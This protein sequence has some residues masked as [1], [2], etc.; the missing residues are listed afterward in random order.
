MM[1][2]G[3]NKL[4]DSIR[5][6]TSECRRMPDAKGAVYLLGLIVLGVLGNHLNIELFFGVNFLF[7][8][9]ATMIAVRASGTLWGTVVGIAIGAYTYFLWGHPYAI[10][11]FGLEAF[12]VGFVVCALKKDNMVLADVGFWLVIGMPLV[13]VLYT[14]QL[15]LP[16][17]PV[18]LIALKQTINGI[19]NTFVATLFLQ[20]APQ[21]L[22]G[23]GVRK[24][25]AK[26]SLTIKAAMNNI[27]A[28]FF[29]LPMIVSITLFGNDEL[30][31][32][33]A[34]LQSHVS[35]EARDIG[36]ELSSVLHSYSSVLK[37][38]IAAELAKDTQQAWAATVDKWRNGIILGL[39][40]VEI[41]NAEGEILFSSPQSRSGRSEYA[42]Q[43]NATATGR[44][45]EYLS[46]Y[47]KDDAVSKGHFT[48]IV[49]MENEKYLVASFSN[50]IFASQLRSIAY[51]NQLIELLDGAGNVVASS[52]EMDLREYVQGDN[53]HQLLPANENLPTMVRWRKAY[54]EDT[55]SLQEGNVWT[56]RVA[57]PMAHAIDTLQEDYIQKMATTIVIAFISLLLTPFVTRS[58]SS[59]LAELTKAADMLTEKTERADVK[60]PTSNIFEVNFLTKNFKNLIDVISEKQTDLTRLAQAVGQLNECVVLFDQDDRIV[61]C[62]QAYRKLNEAIIEYTEPGT[63]FEDHLRAGVRAG[64]MPE[65]I[66]REDEW[67]AERM[68]QHRNPTGSIEVV[69][70][71]DTTTLINEQKLSDGTTVLVISD[72]TEIKHSQAQV[73]QASKL[74]TLG[75]M[76]TSV[77]HEL[78][79][80]LNV[81]RMAAGNIR[82]KLAKGNSDPEYLGQK[83]ERIQ[84]QTERAAAIID[85]M[86]MFGRKADGAD[87]KLDPRTVITNALDL[88]GEQ[89]RLLQIE[90]VTELPDECSSV[91]GNM[92]QME[93]VVINLL[94]NSRDAI[95][96]HDGAK[97]V[98]L[99]VVE[100]NGEVRIIAE[101]TGGG[102]AQEALPRIFE[103][104]YTTK[105]AG[106]G[107]G[108]GMSVSY[109]IIRDMGGTIEVENADAGA[110][111]T[112]TLPTA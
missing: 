82:R 64:I 31:Q 69:R 99:R 55:A 73:I 81:I 5:A 50:E 106:K 23:V 6:L 67:V 8:S 80:P 22:L 2:S 97:K 74:A 51:N 35:D 107:T 94:T 45:L 93:Q 102:I 11:I 63:L 59:P 65:G 19:V 37:S 49:P 96:T 76:A 41:T 20:F 43:V 70:Q 56:V 48:K 58:I 72:I 110:K 111:F 108:L 79:Q 85:H 47:H 38:L 44:H 16:E 34:N 53:P 90:I 39:I 26:R 52:S 54:W 91:M 28:T 57:V 95:A 101:D 77:A 29:I 62:N 83:L 109:G 60:W 33:Q 24:G 15:S 92:I 14:Y 71:N 98:T 9:I 42:V 13:W 75:E 7:G 46:D 12:V 4:R 104:F 17:T 21:G 32:I 18:K 36:H 61:F 3:F 84:D 103:P 78:N 86:R 40:N 68:A 100:E 88:I 89:L 10:Y 87:V 30:K 66:N 1:N 27:I 105:E 25:S 112:I